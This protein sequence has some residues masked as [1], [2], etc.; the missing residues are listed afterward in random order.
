MPSVTFY[1]VTRSKAHSS[2]SICSSHQALKEKASLE[3]AKQLEAEAAKAAALAVQI[4]KEA[5][6]K[7]EEIRLQRE[8]RRGVGSNEAAPL[9]SPTKS[10]SDWKTSNSKSKST[11]NAMMNRE[12]SEATLSGLGEKLETFLDPI[13]DGGRTTSII[14][15]GPVIEQSE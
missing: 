4:E 9:A 10:R 7:S 11:S 12:G 2:Y 8:K 13:E 14:K 1:V 15:I 5:E 6:K 3:R